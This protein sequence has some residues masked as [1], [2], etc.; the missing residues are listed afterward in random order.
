M[1]I[2]YEGAGG[3]VQIDGAEPG[4]ETYFSAGELDAEGDA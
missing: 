2:A 3:Y 1:R 4:D